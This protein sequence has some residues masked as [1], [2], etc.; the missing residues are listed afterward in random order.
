MCV[1]LPDTVT[2]PVLTC[3]DWPSTEYIVAATPEQ[4]GPS[5][6][7]SENAEELAVNQLVAGAVA[8]PD[9]V[10]VGSIESSEK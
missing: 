3:A 6:A 9:A 10:V 2:E 7:V 8:K 1:A 4:I 5:V